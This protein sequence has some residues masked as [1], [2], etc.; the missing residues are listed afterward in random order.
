M[1]ARLLAAARRV[2][3]VDEV[4]SACATSTAVMSRMLIFGLPIS[5]K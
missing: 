5:A 1:T 3:V 4:W 2:G